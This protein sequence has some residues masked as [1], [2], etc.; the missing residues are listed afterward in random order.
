MSDLEKK[1]EAVQRGE[2]EWN[3]D[4]LVSMLGHAANELEEVAKDQVMGKDFR[5]EKVEDKNGK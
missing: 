2:A 4:D 3:H 1:G 5:I